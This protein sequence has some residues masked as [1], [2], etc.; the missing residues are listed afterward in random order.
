MLRI[1]E[2]YLAGLLAGCDCS[3]S[4]PMTPPS[5]LMKLALLLLGM[6]LLLAPA[7]ASHGTRARCASHARGKR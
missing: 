2:G 1:G 7:G 5:A 3:C 6:L 4:V